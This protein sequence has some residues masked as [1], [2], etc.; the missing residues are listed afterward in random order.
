MFMKS[1][2]QE[3]YVVEDIEQAA[4]LLHPTRVEI[5]MKLREARSSAEV[6]R[7]IGDTPQKV[8]YHMKALEKVGLIKKV[9]TRNVRNLIEVLYQAMAKT[10]I[11]PESI[12]WNERLIQ[13]AKDQGSLA[14]MI[15]TS[16]RI[17][18]DAIELMEQSD[19]E[20]QVPSATLQLEV[21]LLDHE[22]RQ[23]FINDYV[24]MM[25]QLVNKYQ[26]SGADEKSQTY[27]IISTIYPKIGG[28]DNK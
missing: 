12:G 16:E 19:Q 1:K 15:E 21:Q 11:L 20:E 3:K 14:H 23:A 24:Q 17:K 2:I 28:E 13:K 9:G 22:H 7:L 18:R 5:L 6:A 27:Q 10:F 25:Q 26:P 4:A 8:N